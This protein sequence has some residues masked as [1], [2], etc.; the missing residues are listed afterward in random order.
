MKFVRRVL[1][2]LLAL[3]V[4]G[5]IGAAGTAYYF[6][7]LISA[8]LP[9]LETLEDYAPPLASVVYDRNG[10]RIGEFFDE[11]RQITPVDQ[12]PQHVIQAFVAA[13]D[14]TFF[15]HTGIDWVSI[16]RAAWVN[17]SAG[18]KI[19]QGASTITQQVAKSLVGNERS[20]IRKL[21]D[22]LLAKRIEERFTKDEILFLYLNQIYFGHGAYG[23]GEA[24][25]SYFGKPV[26]GLD[27]SEAAL[28]A[29]LPKAPSDYSPTVNPEAA[30]QRRLYVLGRMRDQGFIDAEAYENA[31]ASR[32]VLRDPPE[33]ADYAVAA[34]FTE[35]VRR[36]LYRDLGS[37]RVLR[38][39]LRIE[40]T[41]DLDLQF[42]AL[43]SVRRGLE[44]YQQR[45]GGWRGPERHVGITE[46]EA[47]A[48]DLARENHL[49]P[50]APGQAPP[51]PP[52]NQS[53]LGVVRE[54]DPS[55]AR[56]ALAPEIEIEVGLE[57]ATW[58][59]RNP[60]WRGDGKDSRGL[61]Q[62]LRAGD[63]ARFILRPPPL[64]ILPPPATE[65][66][67]SPDADAG[68][69][70]VP[71]STAG[72]A[73]KTAPAPLGRPDPKAGLRWELHQVPSVE[74]SLLSLDVASGDVL[75][76]VG[77][78]DF[79]RSEFNRVTQARRQPGSAIKPF[80]YGASFEWGYSPSSIVLDSQVSLIDPGSGLL[81]APKNYK[82]IFGGAVPMR[83]ALARSLNNAAVHVFLDVGVDNVID[84]ARRLGVRS[85]LGRHLSLSLG[86]T[87]VSLVEL[88]RAYGTFAAGGR[89][90]QPRFIVR[91]LDRKGTPLLENAVLDEL[92]APPDDADRRS[93]RSRAAG[94]RSRRLPRRG[95]RLRAARPG[96]AGRRGVPGDL[97]PARA[98]RPSARHGEAAQAAGSSAGGQDRH[99]QRTERRLVRRLLAADRHRRLGGIRPEED[100]GRQGDRRPHRASDLARLHEHGPGGPSRL[101]LP[102]AGG[103]RVPPGG[104]CR[105]HLRERGWLRRSDPHDAGQLRAVPHAHHQSPQ[106]RRLR[107]QR[108]RMGGGR[109]PE[110]LR[111]AAGRGVLTETRGEAAP[112]AGDAGQADLARDSLAIRRLER[113]A[114]LGELCA[115][116]VHE[117]RNPLASIKTF[118]ELMPEQIDDSEFRGRFLRVVEGELGRMERLIERVLEHA[119][120]APPPGAEAASLGPALA[121]AEELLAH[122]LRANDVRI[123]QAIASPAP[124]VAIAEDSLRQMLLNLL[125]NAIEASPPGARVL[126]DA[127]ASGPLVLIHV[128]DAGPGIAP[129]LREQI[130]EPFF[131]TRPERHGGLGL[132][133]SRR[134]ARE[135]GGELV[136]L[137]SEPP[138]A[139][140]RLSLPAVPEGAPPSRR[141]VGGRGGTALRRA[142]AREDPKR[143]SGPPRAG[144]RGAP[145]RGSASDPRRSRAGRA[146]PRRP[147]P[148][149][150]ARGT[151]RARPGRAWRAGAPPAARLRTRSE[152]APART[153]AAAPAE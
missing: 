22:M 43:L 103:H 5:G 75:A 52:V 144:P 113:M 90:L 19:K 59:F 116:I 51:P 129:G 24:A 72:A 78:Y 132:A 95:R 101:G 118:V 37:A 1:L 18:G 34:G 152:R 136:L 15:R 122:R 25:R 84:Y 74:G 124:C 130:F 63:V 49:E 11:R 93:G 143:R 50:L 100:A 14:D 28:I 20:Y 36:T 83:E 89:L 60:G 126:V 44:I 91:V 33:F 88:V 54:V 125:L 106:A 23:V 107:R 65:E 10:K 135:A 148:R 35:E 142:R 47:T 87:E 104:R 110:Q 77:G 85:P 151:P 114:A 69:Q 112:D 128:R 137:D 21:K 97:S 133:I 153:A 7:Q 48:R 99:H 117:I 13:E 76:M 102:G 141:L 82:N 119:A 120:S 149:A 73:P 61:G 32:P 17:F 46:I 67:A 134:L 111:P 68:S 70:A 115:E 26:S 27:V 81:W 41:L 147:R 30:E 31:V 4:L 131:S 53:L 9:S 86:S 42:A 55:K 71:V 6:Y 127:E 109:A 92:D 145:T 45:H 138:G 108:G 40:T 140:F 121:W 39:G 12:I 66:A 16:V 123:E 80:L 146:D 150:R 56:V 105:D 139:V 57:E 64:P 38:G 2:V 3:G 58:A 62:L 94:G 79:A 98:G 8:D 96:A 29:G